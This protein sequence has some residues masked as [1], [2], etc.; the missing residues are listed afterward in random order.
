MNDSIPTLLL[1]S[2]A[3]VLLAVLGIVALA[4]TSATAALL[5][6]IVVLLAGTA[7]VT[8]TIGRQLDDADGRGDR[9]HPAS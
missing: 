1:V 2:L 4:E 9:R 7:L 8:R 6:A 3:G 5:A